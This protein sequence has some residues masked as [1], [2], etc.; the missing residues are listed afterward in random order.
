LFQAG[1]GLVAIRDSLLVVTNPHRFHG[2]QVIGATQRG[3]VG[4]LDCRLQRTL[5]I[6]RGTIVVSQ[7]TIG[8][9]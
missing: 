2:Q 3:V 1:N 8:H 7:Q 6:L 5:G 4:A 9:P